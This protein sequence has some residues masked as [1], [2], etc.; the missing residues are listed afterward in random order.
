MLLAVIAM[1]LYAGTTDMEV[2]LK[3][4]FP[5]GW[6]NWLWLAF[7]TSFAVKTPM[8][9][10]HTWLPYAHVEAPIV[11]SV[12]LAGILL[13]MG[14]YGF[15]RVSVQMLPGASDTFTTLMFVLS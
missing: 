1:C 13:K 5:H 14:G 15:L 9:P 12:I 8:W 10:V 3:T 6:Q 4:D 7:F 11:G 2:I